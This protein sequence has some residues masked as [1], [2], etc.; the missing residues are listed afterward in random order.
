MLCFR[1][2][3]HVSASGLNIFLVSRTQSKLETAQAE[4]AEEYGVKTKILSIDLVE[5]GSQPL[6]AA[7][8]ADLKATIDTIDVGV[9]INNAAQVQGPP[10]E[11]HEIDPD[12]LDSTVSINTVAVLKVT[13]LVLPG[14]V[15]RG[16]GAIVNVSSVLSS[17][18]AAP[19][20]S[21]YS[22]TKAFMDTFTKAI[23]EEY[24]PKGIDVQVRTA[25][26]A[27]LTCFSLPACPHGL[28][29]P[30]CHSPSFSCFV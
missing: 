22:A 21:L 6:S 1:K 9:L 13:H 25:N 27:W 14:M 10:A 17:M 23:A 18:A 30:S 28:S 19:L 12:S 26:F 11:F 16:R 8:W 15:N 24:G 4:I 3:N 20:V 2:L 29:L 7:V 5:A